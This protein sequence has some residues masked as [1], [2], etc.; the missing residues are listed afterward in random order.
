[1][2]LI[3]QFREERGMSQTDLAKTIGVDPS[4]I[5]CFESGKINPSLPLAVRLADVLTGGSLD[6][7]MGRSP[8]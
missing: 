4:T 7:L 3:K 1:M 5:S 6:K 8:A 2:Y